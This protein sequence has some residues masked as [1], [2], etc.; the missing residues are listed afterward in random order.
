MSA[1]V[2]F[3]APELKKLSA[4]TAG[5]RKY[6]SVYAQNEPKAVEYC[7]RLANKPSLSTLSFSPGIMTEK[8]ARAYVAMLKTNPQLISLTIKECEMDATTFGIIAEGLKSLPNLK[9]LNLQ[10]NRLGPDG[11]TQV[12]ELIGHLPSLTTLNLSENRLEDL[13]AANL[14]AAIGENTTLTSINLEYNRIG[15]EGARS[16]APAVAKNQSLRSFNVAKSLMSATGRMTMIEALN[17]NRNLTSLTIA[18]RTI[19]D[20]EKIAIEKAVLNSGQKNLYSLS[21]SIPNL[22]L[23]DRKKIGAAAIKRFD[24][25]DTTALTLKDFVAVEERWHLIVGNVQDWDIWGQQD[26]KVAPVKKRLDL[27]ARYEDLKSKLPLLGD[28]FTLG[29]LF[30]ANETGFAPIDNPATWQNPDKIFSALAKAD[31]AIDNG[32]LNV[33]SP[34]GMSFLDCAISALPT[35][36]AVNKLNGLGFHLRSKEL[37]NEAGEPSDMLNLIIE[38]GEVRTLFTSDNWDAAHPGELKMVLNAL[39]PEAQEQVPNRHSL[40]G[41]LNSRSNS[42]PSVRGTVNY[43]MLPDTSKF[44]TKLTAQRNQS[45]QSDQSR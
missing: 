31:P 11:A 38:R 9:T 17:G 15:D 16:L 2:E 25:E 13:G 23:S 27:F 44:T 33:R 21:P 6:F 8:I 34:R 1:A 42:I 39:P 5:N 4:L 45:P 43:Q 29:E 24:T 22:K 36:I 12:A 41:A 20:P 7:H 18:K 40:L 35:E 14:A 37:L 26:S 3:E 30:K 19:S 32:F 28:N 10:D